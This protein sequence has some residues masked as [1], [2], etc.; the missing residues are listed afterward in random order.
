MTRLLLLVL[1][2]SGAL[3]CS[4]D[5]TRGRDLPNQWRAA[6]GA[7]RQHVQL[8]G[9]SGF[10]GAAAAI[11]PADVL[12][13]QVLTGIETE[14]VEPMRLRVDAQGAVDVPIIGRVAVAGVEPEA[15][16]AR[17]VAA[18]IERAVYVNPQVNVQFEERASHSVTVLGAVNEPGTKQVPRT[19]C[20]LL[21]AIAA[22]G[23]FTEEAG[24]VVEV[25]R[26]DPA[27]VSSL[28]EGRDDSEIRQVAFE[29]PASDFTRR[30]EQIDLS[31]PAARPRALSPLGDRDV[32]IVR[33]REK[34]VVHVSGLVAEPNQFELPQ[35]HDL[36]VLDAIAMAGGATTAVADKVIVIRQGPE[37]DSPLVVQI[38]I[39]EAKRNGKENLRLQSGDLVSVEPTVATTVAETFTNLFRI[40]MGLGGNLTLF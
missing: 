34:R 20:D 23:G 12:S 15:A 9:L 40:T 13:V 7:G 28:A 30:A 8:T 16:S 36:R 21:T 18:A 35:D 29:G 25:L 2:A 26:H 1:I 11:A 38:S 3:G 22:A 39:A 10:G 33:P 14:P 6:P 32:V 4:A 37:L 17:I 31:N 24:A 5:L 27:S 19:T